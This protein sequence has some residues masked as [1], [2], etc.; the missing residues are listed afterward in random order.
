MS[1]PLGA[2]LSDTQDVQ[3]SES[4]PRD[5]DVDDLNH[6]NCPEKKCPHHDEYT[7]LLKKQVSAL[8]SELKWLKGI[9]T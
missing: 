1:I 7:A 8:E 9:Q 2:D 6:N 4:K 3:I 5:S